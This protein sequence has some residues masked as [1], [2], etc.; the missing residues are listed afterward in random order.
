M[1]VPARRRCQYPKCIIGQDGGS[2]ITQ[3]GLTT[4]DN[5]LKDLEL[6]IMMA[7]AGGVGA[8][9]DMPSEVKRDRCQRPSIGDLATDSDWQYFET[10][11]ASFKRKS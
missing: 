3:E 11:W 10:S 1:T 8:T 9:P 6:H 5:V 2:Y 4:N 7:H